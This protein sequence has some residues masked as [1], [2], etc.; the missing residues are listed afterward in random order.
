MGIND[1]SHH[2]KSKFDSANR[3]VAAILAFVWLASGLVATVLAIT[4]HYWI[5]LVVGPF[6]IAYGLL[7]IR[8]VQ[9]GRRLHWPLHRG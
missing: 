9:T 5:G 6:A 8:V 3:V 2:D 1:K 4:Q 7:W